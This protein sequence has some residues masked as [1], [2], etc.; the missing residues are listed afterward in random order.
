[1][2]R[3]HFAGLHV[4]GEQTH[5]QM[6]REIQAQE[7]NHFQLVERAARLRREFRLYVAKTMKETL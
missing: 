6:R 1:M 4:Y 5:Q 3:F 2:N 7:R